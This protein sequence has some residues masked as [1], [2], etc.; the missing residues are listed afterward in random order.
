MLADISVYA[1]LFW[2]V[3]SEF[4]GIYAH[5]YI[6]VLGAQAASNTMTVF[7]SVSTGACDFIVCSTHAF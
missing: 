3:H 4:H 5:L 1:K 6:F 7:D 2:N